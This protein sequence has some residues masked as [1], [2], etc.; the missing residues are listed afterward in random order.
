MSIRQIKTSLQSCRS[1][2]EYAGVI[3]K[4]SNVRAESQLSKAISASK[5]KSLL[6]TSML[7]RDSINSDLNI[8]H[9]LS[10]SDM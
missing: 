7:K 2:S 4:A 5:R 10:M 3:S 9:E 1:I 6:N 8:E